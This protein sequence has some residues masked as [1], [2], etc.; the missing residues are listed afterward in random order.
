MRKEMVLQQSGRL[1]L[2]MK[3]H[4]HQSS[5]T[6]NEGKAEVQQGCLHKQNQANTEPKLHLTQHPLNLEHQWLHELLH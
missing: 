4:E 5:T 6:Q 1:W 2:S 3:N